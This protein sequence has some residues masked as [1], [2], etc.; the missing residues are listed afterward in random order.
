MNYTELQIGEKTYKLR[1]PIRA[2]VNLEKQLGANPIDTFYNIEQ[3]KLPKLTDMAIILQNAL[4]TYQHGIT[5]NDTFDIIEEFVY[6]GHNVFDLVPII[7]NVFTDSGFIA[8]NSA[9]AN[10]DANSK[11]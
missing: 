8:T 2:I 3:G 10:E 5:L 1:L 4:N 7:I 6:N 11:N 9:D